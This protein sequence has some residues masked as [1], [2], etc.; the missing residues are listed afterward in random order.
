MR[1]MTFTKTLTAAAALV[2]SAAFVGCGGTEDDEF[3][4]GAET[5]SVGGSFL[6]PRSALTADV[7]QIQVI[8][9]KGSRDNTALLQNCQSVNLANKTF[10]KSDMVKFYDGN[11]SSRSFV[12]NVTADELIAG[13]Q[14]KVE[15]ETGTNYVFIVELIAGTSDGGSQVVANGSGAYQKVAKGTN[16]ALNITL[17]QL[18]PA[19]TC[20]P[21]ID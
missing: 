18:S 7:R 16:K 10:S 9:L 17:S 19:L 8:A 1:T 3:S 21:L 4:D 14:I 5:G 20:E 11:D 2:L 12:Q 13:T 15:V 6:I